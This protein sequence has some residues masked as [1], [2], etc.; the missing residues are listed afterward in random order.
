MWGDIRL[1]SLCAW[2]ECRLELKADL[3]VTSGVFPEPFL[4]ELRRLHTQCGCGPVLSSLVARLHLLL[5]VRFFLRP[6]FTITGHYG[7]VR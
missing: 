4:L 7:L 1:A 6:T 3:L 2:E 5:S